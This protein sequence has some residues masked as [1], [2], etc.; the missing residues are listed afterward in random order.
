MR[1]SY[2]VRD[3]VLM[4]IITGAWVG[5]IYGSFTAAVVVALAGVV[6]WPPVLVLINWLSN[7][8]R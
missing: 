4:M 5:V 2:L 1:N 8:G 7:R 6:V 3:T